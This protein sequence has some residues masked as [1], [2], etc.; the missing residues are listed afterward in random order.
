VLTVG[1]AAPAGAD[2][3]PYFGSWLP[4]FTS[5]SGEKIEQFP[6]NP[7]SLDSMGWGVQSPG[8]AQVGV[9][10]QNEAI[11]GMGGASDAIVG[12]EEY[13]ISAQPDW[14]HGGPD[15]CS[16]TGAGRR[17]RW[18]WASTRFTFALEEL[19]PHHQSQLQLVIRDLLTPGHPETVVAT[20][21][22]PLNALALDEP[23]AEQFDLTPWQGREISLEFRMNSQYPVGNWFRLDNLRRR[24]R[25][26]RPLLGALSPRGIQGRR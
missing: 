5:F 8:G 6:P 25:A 12:G 17:D 20:Y 24:G 16:S 18:V 10:G 19:G 21:N 14:E 4:H 11:L 1:L 3:P 22:S 9:N 15:W 26:P 2:L 7:P 23:Q 13:V